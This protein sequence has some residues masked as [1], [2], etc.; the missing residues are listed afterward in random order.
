MHELLPVVSGL[1]LGTFLGLLPS[2]MRLR[3]GA[4]SAVLLG[5]T[6][7]VV[8]GEWLISWSFLLIDIPIVAGAAAAALLLTHRLRWGRVRGTTDGSP[9]HGRRD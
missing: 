3:M 1:V 7:T 9:R 2:R 4:V 6:A 8:S 5:L